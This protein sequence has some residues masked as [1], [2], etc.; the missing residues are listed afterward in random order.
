M[1]HAAVERKLEVFEEA[2]GRVSKE[3]QEAHREIPWKD[4]KGVR[5]ILAHKYADIELGVIWEAA[6]NELPLIL[7]KIEQLMKH[8]EEE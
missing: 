6:L 1:L 3:M 8:F 5:V 4:I 2:A 7:P